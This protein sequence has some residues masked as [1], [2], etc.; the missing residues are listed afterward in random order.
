MAGDKESVVEGALEKEAQK[1]DGFTR[2]FTS[3]G[4]SGVPDRIVFLPGGIVG[5]IE[6]KRPQGGR[7]SALQ[8]RELD[9]LRAMGVRVAV[10]STVAEVASTIRE[11]AI[12][13]RVA[14]TIAHRIASQT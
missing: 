10:V 13:G 5:F 8:Q 9:S 1:H 6:C 4:R 11:W 3:P 2:K 12:E 14:Q 7:V